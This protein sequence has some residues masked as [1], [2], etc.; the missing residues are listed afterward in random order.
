MELDCVHVVLGASDVAQA[1]D[2]YVNKL[3][4]ALMDDN[5]GFFAVRAGG[6]RVSVFGGGKRLDAEKEETPNLKL[7]LRTENIESSVK[8][9]KKRGVKFDGG[10]VD[11]PGFMRFAPVLD[12][13]NNV[14]FLAQYASDPL[15]APKPKPGKKK[16]AHKKRKR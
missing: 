7:V 13:D 11:A 4:L 8:D 14:I 12:P 5:P 2:F 15:K 9:L 10:I 16:P 3:G 1:R 6:V